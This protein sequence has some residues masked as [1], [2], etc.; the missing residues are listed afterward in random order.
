MGEHSYLDGFS[1]DSIEAAKS[2]M[3][4]ADSSTLDV[5]NPEELK[6]LLDNRHALVEMGHDVLADGG[7]LHQN[8]S[9]DGVEHEID[10]PGLTDSF[11]RNAIFHH[12]A[13]EGPITYI[14]PSKHHADP[15]NNHQP[16]NT[17]EETTAAETQENE[18]ETIHDYVQTPDASLKGVPFERI[19]EHI[20][21]LPLEQQDR[22]IGQ[23]FQ[24]NP[25]V[26]K[27]MEM[28]SDEAHKQY[29]LKTQ[30]FESQFGIDRNGDSIS[31]QMEQEMKDNPAFMKEVSNATTDWISETSGNEIEVHEAIN[32]IR[33]NNPELF[34]QYN[35]PQERIDDAEFLQRIE[36]GTVLDHLKNNDTPETSTA[37][38]AN[39]QQNPQTSTGFDHNDNDLTQDGDPDI[40]AAYTGNDPEIGLPAQV[41]PSVATPGLG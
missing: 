8:F 17:P 41:G 29:D 21:D 11:N 10:T 31:E 35:I 6:A 18:N 16:Q 25:G 4:G 27:A 36:D 28:T 33:E 39:P 40:I 2:L 20:K 26:L 1:Q 30:E 7:E 24:D 22:V 23:Y 38:E 5:Q 14:D 9:Y 37:P 3:T 12:D 15:N 19:A 32:Y 34:K 13:P